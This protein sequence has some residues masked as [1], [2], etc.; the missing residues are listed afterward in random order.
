MYRE[1]YAI[2]KQQIE[3]LK[4]ELNGK[5]QQAAKRTSNGIPC[6]LVE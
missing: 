3:K 2:Q 4:K 1:M 5:A 6:C